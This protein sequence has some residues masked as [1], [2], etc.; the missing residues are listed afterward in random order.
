[1]SSLGQVQALYFS[2]TD[3]AAVARL[4]FYFLGQLGDTDIHQD[5]PTWSWQKSSDSKYSPEG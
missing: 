4:G 1:M 5:N 3:V 2:R